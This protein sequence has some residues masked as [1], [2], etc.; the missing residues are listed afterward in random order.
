MLSLINTNRM[1][2]P[3]A[4]LGLAYVA[5]AARAAG[6]ETEVVDLPLADDPAKYLTDHFRRAAPALVGL[7]FR[8]VDDCFW[9]SGKSFLP[10]LAEM[11]AAIRALTEA[12][13]VLGGVGF[14]IFGR[15]I[16]RHVGA[17]FG[18]R[19]DGERAIVELYREVT[20]G[21][22]YHRVPGLVWNTSHA[23]QR[24]GVGVGEEVE[25]KVQCNAPAWSDP[26][27][28]PTARD[29]L[30]NWEYFRLGGQGGVETKRG[31]PRR[32]VY[33]ADRLAK[34][35][36]VRARAPVEV[37]DEVQSLLRQGVDVLHLCDGEFNIP[38][39]HAMAVC[40]VLSARGLGRRVRWYAYLAVTPF[41]AELAAA[42]AQAGCVGIN[43]TGDSA[44][45]A[46]L[47]SYGHPHGPEDIQAA[48]RLCRDHG[49]AVMF[50][51]LLGGPGET[52]QTLAETIGFME[53]LDADAIGAALGVRVYPHLPIV[54]LIAAEGPMEANPAIRRHYDGPVDLLLPTFYISSALGESPAALVRDLIGD[55][56]RFFKPALAI[57]APGAAAGD[58]N[59]NDNTPLA[60]AIANGARGAYWHI[61]RQMG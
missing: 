60:E 10:E 12:P 57:D 17:D 11:V 46:M 58:H 4:P 33:C 3:I 37:A 26:F 14:S 55:D 51:L 39:E 30:D 52:P 48:A 9:P 42:M 15:R 20:G 53:G 41:D 16:V 13:I 31:C 59:Y 29:V 38:R 45:A 40:K 7:S 36:R 8:N 24:V 2:P 44:A 1:S 32:C 43:F 21:G 54:D 27:S 22:E 23:A 28:V 19:G 18:I 35:P 61:L 5:A 34:G 25:G 56:E 47:A 6:I 49:M 50:D